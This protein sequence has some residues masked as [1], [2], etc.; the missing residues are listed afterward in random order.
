MSRRQKN[1]HQSV[2]QSIVVNQLLSI[3]HNLHKA[4]DAYP[5]RETGGVFLDIPKAFD[6]V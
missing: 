2:Y 6:K 4:F 3:V 1:Y 5:T